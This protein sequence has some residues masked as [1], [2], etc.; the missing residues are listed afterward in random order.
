[1]SLIRSLTGHG[2]LAV[3]GTSCYQRKKEMASCA[4]C[5]SLILFG[6]TRAGDLRFCDAKC[7]EKGRLA[8][9]ANELPQA[10]VAKYLG[11]VH[12]G[13]CPECGGAGPVDLHTSHRVWSAVF[14]TSWA[15]RPVISCRPCGVKRQLGDGLFSLLFG[16]W[17]VPW[18]ILMTPVQVA[19]NVVSLVRAPDPSRPSN[20]LEKAVR[21]RM[22]SAIRQESGA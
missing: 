9:A 8:F 15:S 11:Q 20:G 2:L 4:Y 6:G 13:R 18:G 5:N 7:A 10:E 16:W 12:R 17:G 1:M 19:K 14:M 21:L 3:G 22:A